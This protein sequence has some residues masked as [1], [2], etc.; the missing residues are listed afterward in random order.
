MILHISPFRSTQSTSI[1]FGPIQFIWSTLVHYICPI[2]SR[3]I[4]SVYF[5]PFYPL[6]SNCRIWLEGKAYGVWRPGSKLPIS[7][8]GTRIV[9]VVAIGFSLTAYFYLCW[10]Q[11]FFFS[12]WSWGANC[13]WLIWCS[14]VHNLHQFSFSFTGQTSFYLIEVGCIC[15]K[16]C[17]YI[18]SILIK[19]RNNVIFGHIDL[20]F[21][22]WSLL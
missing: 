9:I 1:H 14:N 18:T 6:W 20:A 19:V 4:R 7:I 12:N 5:S 10:N 15:F 3:S 22:F 13:L 8:N 16:T 11:T 17:N 21:T 2:R